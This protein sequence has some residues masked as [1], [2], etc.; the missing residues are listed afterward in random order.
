MSGTNLQN[1]NDN[2]N[3]CIKTWISYSHVFYPTEYTIKHI[4]FWHFLILKRFSWFFWGFFGF[5]FGIFLDFWDLFLFSFFGFFLKLFFD[6]LEVIKVT[7]NSYWGYYKTPKM[8]QRS[9]KASAV[10]QSPLQELEVKPA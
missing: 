10:G 5:L 8:A 1:V 2:K 3:I 9:K 7:T 6:F 4:I